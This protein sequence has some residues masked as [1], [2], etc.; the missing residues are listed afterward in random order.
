[1]TYLKPTS[2]CLFLSILSQ[3]VFADDLTFVGTIKQ[4]L[5]PTH[6]NTSLH[7]Q[8][9]DQPHTTFITLPEYTL[10]DATQH[11]IYQRAQDALKTQKSSNLFINQSKKKQLGM[12]QVPVLNQGEHG[13]CATFA[14]TAAAD[15]VINKG[16]RISP[17]CLLQLGNYLET[18]SLGKSGWDGINIYETLNRLTHYGFITSRNQKKYGCGNVYYYPYYE[19][20]TPYSSI[21]LDAYT[22][23]RDRSSETRFTWEKIFTTINRTPNERINAIKASIDAG[24]RVIVSTL[25]PASD[26]GTAGATGRHHYTND[27]W[28]F[29]EEIYQRI[30]YQTHFSSHAMVITGYDD[31]AFATDNHGRRHRGLLTLRN[32]WGSWVADWGDF[33]MSYDYA[34]ILTHRGEQLFDSA[35]KTSG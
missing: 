16:D 17:L 10:S 22:K 28:I 5:T 24:H 18:R 33:Y 31:D 1:M 19:V 11:L 23:R 14:V 34:D 15:A 3:H 2:L 8:P 26:L 27:T 7:T 20:D 9:Q 25:L 35:G 12:G 32:S 29:T 6:I 4:P 30:K 13:T 21:S